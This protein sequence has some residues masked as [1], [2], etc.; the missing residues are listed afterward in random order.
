MQAEPGRSFL[1]T[2]FPS[3]WAFPHT[4]YP[5]SLSTWAHKS[6]SLPPSLWGAKAFSPPV[7]DVTI[8]YSPTLKWKG[9][10]SH[11]ISSLAAV[12]LSPGS[13]PSL[14]RIN[15]T[16]SDFKPAPPTRVKEVE[17]LFQKQCFSLG[18]TPREFKD[19]PWAFC[20]C[21]FSPPSLYLL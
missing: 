15:E 10:S 20:C 4:S 9:C 17:I 14:L 1:S 7:S 3:L 6:H 21:Y 12:S 13:P 19:D 8:C 18:K 2:L 16:L 11:S 5:T